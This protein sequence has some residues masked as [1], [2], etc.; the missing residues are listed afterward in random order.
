MTTGDRC[1]VRRLHLGGNVVGQ[2]D[3]P[4]KGL[5]QPVDVDLGCA[6]YTDARRVLRDQL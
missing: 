2:A 5:P 1:L 6:G 4:R 3:L